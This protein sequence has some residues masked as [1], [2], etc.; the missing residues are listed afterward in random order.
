MTAERIDE[1]AAA[2]N[3]GEEPACVPIR[4]A[5]DPG[6]VTGC[7]FRSPEVRRGQ[8]AVSAGAEVASWMSSQAVACALSTAS[9]T[10]PNAWLAMAPS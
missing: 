5:G 6:A 4:I 3:A 2:A 10:L 7:R 8:L 9:V 1:T